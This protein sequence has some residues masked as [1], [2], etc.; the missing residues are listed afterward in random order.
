LDP[1]PDPF[2]DPATNLALS[3]IADPITQMIPEDRYTKGRVR[4]IRGYILDMYRV[5]SSTRERLRPGGAAVYVV[6][7]SVHGRAPNHFIIAADLLL[8]RIAEQVGFEVRRLE[9]ARSLRRRTMDSAQLR[10]SVV[11]LK[12]D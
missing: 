6:G 11:F 1:L 8:A 7:N 10:E 2:L 12:R 5:L 3:S 9:I 4:M